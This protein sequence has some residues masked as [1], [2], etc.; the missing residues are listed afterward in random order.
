MS[1]RNQTVRFR[2]TSGGFWRENA[3]SVACID[4]KHTF[5]FLPPT[6]GLLLGGGPQGFG[7]HRGTV[8]T[9]V[10][11]VRLLQEVILALQKHTHKLKELRP[12]HAPGGER[13]LTRKIKL[14]EDAFFFFPVWADFDLVFFGLG[15]FFTS[16]TLLLLFRTPGPETQEA[17]TSGAVILFWKCVPCPGRLGLTLPLFGFGFFDGPQLRARLAAAQR[18]RLCHGDRFHG[19]GHGGCHGGGRCA[20]EGVVGTELSPLGPQH[21]HHLRHGDLGVLLGDEGPE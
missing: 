15:F 21:C 12:Q 18:R 19:G 13:A 2:E 20:F 17:E 8:D 9:D 10:I 7:K 4:S 3:G 6:S 11:K 16:F 1:G 14:T 5:P